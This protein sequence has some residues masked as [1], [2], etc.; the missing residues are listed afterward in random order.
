MCQTATSRDG[1]IL[2]KSALAVLKN[3]SATERVE[4][5]RDDGRA[6]ERVDAILL[7]RKDVHQLRHKDAT[8]RADAERTKPERQDRQRLAGE[9]LLTGKLRAAVQI[10]SGVCSPLNSRLLYAILPPVSRL[11]HKEDPPFDFSC[12]W[13]RCKPS[14]RLSKPMVGFVKSLGYVLK[15][16]GWIC[17]SLRLDFTPYPPPGKPLENR[18]V[19]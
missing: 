14:L 11:P 16:R 18:L 8:R 10:Q 4:D 17:P 12:R 5:A 1:N 7:G 19:G 15:R 9:E 2:P 13:I 6:D 3:D